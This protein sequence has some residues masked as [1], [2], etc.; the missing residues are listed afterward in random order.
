M[1]EKDR[2]E[3]RS[4][5]ILDEI[6]GQRKFKS[7][8]DIQNTDLTKRT[9]QPNNIT[10]VS[11]TAPTQNHTFNQQHLRQD[12]W[13]FFSQPRF[14]IVDKDL[15][16]PPASPSFGAL[17][18]VG[19]GS[20]GDWN[21][22][23]NNLA[24]KDSGSWVFLAATEGYHAD[25]I[26][27]DSLYRFDGST[28]NSIM[29]KK[30]TQDNTAKTTGNGTEIDVSGNSNNYKHIACQVVA[31]GTVSGGTVLVQGSNLTGASY[32]TV[33]TFDSLA[34]SDNLYLN[35][36]IEFDFYRYSIS[37]NITGGGSVDILLRVLN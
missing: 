20:G 37:S 31:N 34:T 17:Y 28:W 24:N 15:T 23:D 11:I 33:M 4:I 9:F 2:D 29:G 27:E 36:E 1:S 35:T 6:K 32:V 21:A 10:P 19:V 30:L 22:Q 3:H 5:A 25:V 12:Q 7:V 14:I 18:I 16:T 8:N 26:D 13:Q